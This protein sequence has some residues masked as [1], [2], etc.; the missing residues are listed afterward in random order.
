M[1]IGCCGAGK[2]TFSHRLQ[3]VTGLELI[4][5]DQYHWKPNWVEIDRTEWEKVVQKLAAKPQWI[6]DGNFSGTLSIRMER[7][8][9][10]IYFDFPT[11]FCLWRV[12]KRIWTYHGK[13]R[14]DMTEGCPERFDLEF[15]HY[16]ATFN[17]VKRKGILK[18]LDRVKGSKSIQVFK[19]D[20]EAAAFLNTLI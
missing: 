19:N 8:D 13:T 3:A 4:H 16:V 7:A 2:S 1:V 5:L 20:R 12:L 18:Q 17:W 11:W 15:L 6:M 10:I 14:P 9:T